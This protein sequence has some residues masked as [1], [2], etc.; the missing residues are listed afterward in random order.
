M[1]M[2]EDLLPMECGWING[3][4][5]EVGCTRAKGFWHFDHEDS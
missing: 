2:V 5:I 3:V 4:T 1:Q